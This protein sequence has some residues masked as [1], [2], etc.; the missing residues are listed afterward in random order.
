MGELLVEKSDFVATITL[1]RPERLN[2]ISVPMLGALSEALVDADKD[3][4]VRV[5]VLTGAGRG[6]C[7]GLDLQD[8]V[9]G[10]GIGS[11]K[12]VSAAVGRFDLRDAPP[13]VL[14][15]LDKP[16]ICAL[17]GG[18]AGYGM[19]LALGCD[20]RIASDASKLSAA[21][22]KRG[23]LPES[24]GTWLLHL[25]THVRQLALEIAANAPL[26]VQ[27]TK[28]MMRMGQDETFEAN[29]HHVYL[30]LLPLFRSQDFKEGVQ[31]FLEKREP[32]FEGR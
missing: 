32:K 16:T 2:A 13:T 12:G 27:A 7:A 14:H 30:Q 8:Q 15:S 20:I 22:T 25:M 10:E 23:V 28:R 11:E 1:N 21:F 6:F 19:D 5:V 9:S 3:P 18:A 17:N 4:E 29:V 24:G 31:S 26:A